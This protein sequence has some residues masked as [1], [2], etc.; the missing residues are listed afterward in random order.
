MTH[1]KR[2]TNVRSPVW[3]FFNEIFENENK[4]AQFVFC[5][6]CKSV[7]FRPNN[8]T[9]IMLR[10]MQICSTDAN[11]NNVLPKQPTTKSIVSQEDKERLKLAAAKFVIKDIRPYIAVQGNGLLDLCFACVEFGKKYRKAT[12]EDLVTSMPS[13]NTVRNTVTEI[14]ERSRKDISKLFKKAIATGGIGATTD[15]WSDDFMKRTYI[16]VVA[17]VATYEN[18]V[19]EYH[20]FVLCTSEVTEWIKTGTYLRRKK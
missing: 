1:K 16:S 8:N 4:I 12:H 18:E 14:A 2:E 15:T 10:H 19:L 11:N 7:L 6:K 17:H 13:R 3:N 20:R 5:I 9:N